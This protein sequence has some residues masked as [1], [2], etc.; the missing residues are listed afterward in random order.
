MNIIY[1]DDQFS[2]LKT[3][4]DEFQV[5]DKDKILICSTFSSTGA[6]QFVFSHYTLKNFGVDNLPDGGDYDPPERIVCAA[7]KYG[8]LVIAGVRHG[9]DTLCDNLETSV[10]YHAIKDKIDHWYRESHHPD[11]SEGHAS[12]YAVYRLRPIIA[13]H[14]KHIPVF[15]RNEE[16]EGF[17]TSKYR[18]VNRQEAWKIAVE[19]NQIVRRCGNDTEH[20][21]TLYSENLY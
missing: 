14:G 4:E 10:T 20:G 8:E 13:E 16:I 15:K 2:I 21:G 3:E 7:N 18:F 19:Q 1:E 11:Y 5:F 9:C 17:L 12:T 6:I